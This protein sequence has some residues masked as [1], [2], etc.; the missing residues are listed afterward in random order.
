MYLLLLFHISAGEKSK[1]FPAMVPQAILNFEKS[2]LLISLCILDSSLCIK[3]LFPCF[4]ASDLLVVIM[5]HKAQ[6]SSVSVWVSRA[7][8]S[9]ILCDSS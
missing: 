1:L 3:M 4:Y 6:L 2:L 9:H 5:T 8:F 7:L